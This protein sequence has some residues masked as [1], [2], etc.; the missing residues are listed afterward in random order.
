MALA[1][2]Q[3]SITDMVDNN[4]TERLHRVFDSFGNVHSETHYDSSGSVVASGQTGYIDEAFEYTG[5]LFDKDTG[6]Q[7][8][9][10]RW[11]DPKIGR[12]LSE[13][14]IGLGP[15][16]NP[17]RYVGN[18]PSNYIDPSGL[19]A[20]TIGIGIGLGAGELGAVGTGAA[21]VGGGVAVAGAGYCGYRIG[22]GIDKAGLNPLTPIGVA[23]GG[24]IIKS[25][26][27]TFDDHTL[28]RIEE[29][30]G[31]LG[32]IERK[33]DEITNDVR[34]YGKHCVDKSVQ[35]LEQ[36]AKELAEEILE[37]SKQHRGY[38]GPN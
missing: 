11:Y 32:D 6:L 22:Q 4:G 28:R 12:W 13:D 1:D 20:A 7:N 24:G 36:I 34:G 25:T 30:Q 27:G 37:L 14:P 26:P 33:I 38:I 10:N 16:V 21:V 17:Y 8:N 31:Q 29:L 2:R 9:L 3:G 15:D 5:R 23:I 35:R 18:S 19:E